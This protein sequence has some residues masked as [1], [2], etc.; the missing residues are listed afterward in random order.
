LDGRLRGLRAAAARLISADPAEIA[1]VKNTSEG[2]ATVAMGIDWKPGDKV[3]AFVEE[4]PANYFPWKRL[5][6]R[7]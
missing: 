6:A 4:F 3:V 2:I 5:E 1:L 7:R